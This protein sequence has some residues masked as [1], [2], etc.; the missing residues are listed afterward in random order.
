MNNNPRSSV[1]VCSITSNWNI[2]QP[3]CIILLMY[4]AGFD[5]IGTLG[6]IFAASMAPCCF[7]LI[8]VVGT[9]LGL[10]VIEQYVPYLDLAIQAF[11]I[12]AVFGNFLTFRMHRSLFPFLLS[13]T[14]AG[15]IFYYYYVGWNDKLVYIGFILL[16]TSAIW[17]TLLRRRFMK[18]Q[19][20]HVIENSVIT[21]PECSFTKEEK[22]P[23]DSCQFF[24]ECP[25]CKAVLKPKKGDCCVFCSYG[26][27]PCPPIQ[28]EGSCCS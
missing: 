27:V 19:S 9:A 7:P 1:I 22:M 8:G 24:W 6:A 25:S 11:V 15:L 10:T 13:I 4:I 23:T 14:G 18:S 3:V 5:K 2:S 16:V 17:N 28:Q 26:S 21:C 20:N 12:I